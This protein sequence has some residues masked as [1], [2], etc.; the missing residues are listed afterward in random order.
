MSGV[1]AQLFSKG[2]EEEVEAGVGAV[3]FVGAGE[4]LEVQAGGV[5][6]GA[7][8]FAD[9]LRFGAGPGGGKKLVLVAGLYLAR[10]G[11]D[12]A[13]VLDLQ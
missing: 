13:G 4:D 3:E 2:V 8:E 1:G 9:F 11:A 10:A 5:A 6:G 12:G 7:V